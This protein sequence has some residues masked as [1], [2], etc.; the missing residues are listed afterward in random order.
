VVGFENIGYEYSNFSNWGIGVKYTHLD[1]KSNDAVI[2]KSEYIYSF[3]GSIFESGW[4]MATGLVLLS[5]RDGSDFL[6]DSKNELGLSLKGGYSYFFQN[7]FSA[8]VFPEIWVYREGI[9]SLIALEAGY[10]F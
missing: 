5:D 1:N 6:K 8:R 4:N 7:K 2:L 9:T 10:N 3:T